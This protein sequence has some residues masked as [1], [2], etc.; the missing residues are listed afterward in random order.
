MVGTGGEEAIET[1]ALQK[2]PQPKDERAAPGRTR[3]SQPR[4]VDE[5]PP[6]TSRRLCGGPNEG[7]VKSSPARM[8]MS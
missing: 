7:H 8:K 1:A 3:A 2:N 4:A 5:V 6:G